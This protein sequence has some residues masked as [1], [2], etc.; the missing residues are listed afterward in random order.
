VRTTEGWTWR[1]SLAAVTLAAAMLGL[2][3]A[4]PFVL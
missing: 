4:I 3:G 2:F 1:R